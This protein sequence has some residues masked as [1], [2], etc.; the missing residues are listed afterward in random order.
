ML[1]LNF[2][3]QPPLSSP[4]S[5]QWISTC[6]YT[7]SESN[8]SLFISSPHLTHFPL[9]LSLP[10]KVQPHSIA[11]MFPKYH[12]FYNRSASSP[13]FISFTR[14]K[15]EKRLTCCLVFIFPSPISLF[16]LPITQNKWDPPQESLF[17]CVSSFCF[18]HSILWFLSD[19]LWKLKT[20]FS[21]FQFP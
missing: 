9:P 17:G 18:H 19:E 11:S 4:F 5:I 8:Y 16:P 13:N 15:D 3:H 7:K 10:S 12:L 6:F 1:A 21:C 2:L 20:H 14:T